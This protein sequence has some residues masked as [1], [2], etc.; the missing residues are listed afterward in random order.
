MM[1]GTVSPVLRRILA[2]A[3][4]A[5]VM[6]SV[7]GVVVEPLS[8]LWQEQRTAADRQQKMLAA[9]KRSA[10]ELPALSARRDALRKQD[11]TQSGFLEGAGATV[12]AAKLQTDVKRMIESQ[13]GQVT[14]MQIL[15]VATV[16][17]FDKIAVRVDFKASTDALPRIVHAIEAGGNGAG[18]NAPALF[19]ENIS[20]R[21]PETPLPAAVA[22]REPELTVRWDVYGFARRAP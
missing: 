11:A 17:G 18:G 15:P 16:D 10:A 9:Y 12:I 14:S 6:F 13:P 22:A 1:L 7:W 19:V 3:I 21:A 20:V 5:G 8:D 4:L 2:L